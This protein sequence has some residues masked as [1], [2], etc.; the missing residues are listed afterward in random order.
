[1]SPPM[2][3]CQ[4]NKLNLLLILNNGMLEL[5]NKIDKS[6]IISLTTDFHYIT[7]EKRKNRKQP[8]QNRKNKIG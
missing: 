7:A 1:M 8:K 5:K 4:L 6:V 3:L 2:S